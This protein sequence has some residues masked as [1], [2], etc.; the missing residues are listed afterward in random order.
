[1]D[2]EH[3]DNANMLVKVMAREATTGAAVT[4]Q[5]MDHSY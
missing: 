2:F 5:L 3:I 4:I 1:M